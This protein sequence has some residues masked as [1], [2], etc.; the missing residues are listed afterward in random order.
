MSTTFQA[1]GSYSTIKAKRV[2]AH[3]PD[4][5]KWVLWPHV[6]A[7]SERVFR[8]PPGRQRLVTVCRPWRGCAL[9]LGQMR[10]EPKWP[11]PARGCGRPHR[12]PWSGR[13]APAATDKPEVADGTL[14]VPSVLAWL[15]DTDSQ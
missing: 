7:V 9:M 5:S 4:L 8:G 2:A 10:R 1:L 3:G 11:K 13:E 15:E 12:L 6:R 14:W